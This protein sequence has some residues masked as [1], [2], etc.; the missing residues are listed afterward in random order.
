MTICLNSYLHTSN[1]DT[2]QD[3]LFALLCVLPESVD[4]L[5]EVFCG[6]EFLEKKRER[7]LDKVH[8]TSFIP[9]VRETGI[10]KLWG[11]KERGIHII[12]GKMRP[13]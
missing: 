12:H 3:Y 13:E 11:Q 4:S 10:L 6:G 8:Y 5:L 2:E 7:R 1:R 9:E